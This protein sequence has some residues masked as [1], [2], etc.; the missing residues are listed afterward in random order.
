MHFIMKTKYLSFICVGLITNVNFECPWPWR[1]SCDQDK[2]LVLPK[3][4]QMLLCWWYIYTKIPLT[5]HIACISLYAK[6]FMKIYLTDLII[7]KKTKI[8]IAHNHKDVIDTYNKVNIH[9]KNK[10]SVCPSMSVYRMGK[11]EF[12]WWLTF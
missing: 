11:L 12:F 9:V 1:T 2:E 8:E 10:S 7:K 6:I 4:N 3:S 5:L